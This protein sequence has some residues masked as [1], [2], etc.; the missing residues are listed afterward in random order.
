MFFK[1]EF[2]SKAQVLVLKVMKDN[3]TSSTSCLIV[4]T[5]GPGRFPGIAGNAGNHGEDGKLHKSDQ[6]LN[7]TERNINKLCF[8]K[9]L[10]EKT[11]RIKFYLD[12]G[13]RSSSMVKNEYS[14]RPEINRKLFKSKS[15]Q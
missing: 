7:Q 9:I 3:S 13:S 5:F 8:G 1:F 4:D 6:I 10:L 12:S 15:T 11:L 2:N 14:E